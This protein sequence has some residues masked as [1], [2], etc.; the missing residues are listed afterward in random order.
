MANKKIFSSS[1]FLKITSLKDKNGSIDK[2][3]MIKIIEAIYD[4]LG[5]ENR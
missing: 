5:E 1:L 4:L 3:E 2:K